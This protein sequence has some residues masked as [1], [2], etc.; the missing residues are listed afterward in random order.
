[1]IN[2]PTREASRWDHL[3]A[4]IKQMDREIEEL[5]VQRGVAGMRSRFVMPIIRLSHEGPL[6]VSQLAKSL[7]STHSATSQTV[8]AM[9]RHGF[10]TSAPGTD[11][12]TQVVALTDYARELVPLLEAEW[13]AT[14]AVTDELDDELGGTV[15]A[16]S[17]RLGAAL[18]SRSMT[19]RLNDHLENVR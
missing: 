1:M 18:E 2:D 5:Y 12:R 7:G 8:T 6:T 13:R 16:L 19:T 10:I 11:A 15:T 9:K 17:E 3:F 14:N 4:L